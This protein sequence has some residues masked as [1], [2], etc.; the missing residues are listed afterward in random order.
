MTAELLKVKYLPFPRWTA[1]FVAAVVAIMGVVLAVVEPTEP[2]KYVS[3]PHSSVG[4]VTALTAIVFGV[5]ASTLEFAAGTLQRT[6]IAEPDRRR[7]LAAKLALVIA[8]T[9]V[10]G[11]LVAAAAGGLSHLAANRAG[12]EIDDGDLAGDLFGSIPSWVSGAVIGYGFGLLGRSLGGG[13]AASFV[14]VLAFDGLVSFIP[15]AQDYTYGQ[16]SS[17][18]VNH[19]GATG[20][21]QNGFAVALAGTIAWCAVIVVPGWIRFTRGDLK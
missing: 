10:A 17:D 18:M 15:G 11:L 20:A 19:L 21:T 7:V 9:A 12:V 2:D 16:L 4:L 13:I 6:L 3:I 1:A 14:F 8:V 5:W